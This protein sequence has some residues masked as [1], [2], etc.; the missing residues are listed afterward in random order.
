MSEDYPILCTPEVAQNIY[1]RKQWQ[2]RRPVKYQNDIHEFYVADRLMVCGVGKNRSPFGE[3][4]DVLYVRETWQAWNGGWWHEAAGTLADKVCFNWDIYYRGEEEYNR[5]HGMAEMFSLPPRW[6]PSI[7]MPKWASRM[8]LR[9]KWVW[10][11]RVQDIDD[12][13]AIAEGMAADAYPSPRYN[14]AQ[15]WMELY[16]REMWDSNPWVWCCEFE[17]APPVSSPNIPSGSI[18]GGGDGVDSS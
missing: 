17:L 6:I 5:R 11:E 12:D 14:F 10:V 13:G 1:L 2:D 3:E 15:L 16:G 8:K 4:G 18:Q 7:H 9:V